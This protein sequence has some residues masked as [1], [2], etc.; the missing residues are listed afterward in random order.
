MIM[1]RVTRVT[2]RVG[3]PGA[4]H[5]GGAPPALPRPHPRYPRHHRRPRQRQVHRLPPLHHCLHRAIHHHSLPMCQLF[6]T[7]TLPTSLV[8]GRS[9]GVR[10]PGKPSLAF[11]PHLEGFNCSPNSPLPWHSCLELFDWSPIHNGGKHKGIK[12]RQWGEKFSMFHAHKI[13]LAGFL[14]NYTNE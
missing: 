2:Q 11:N 1:S 14:L 6:A 13:S 10:F 7:R 4:G 8:L 12:G 9:G 5:G 3:V